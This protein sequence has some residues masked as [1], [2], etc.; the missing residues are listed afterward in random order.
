MRVGNA[1]TEKVARLDRYKDTAMLEG[2]QF[3]PYQLM[4]LLG[5]GGM[6][7]VYLAYDE[8]REREV[9][10]KVFVGHNA[11]Y[12]ERFR[13][14]AEAIDKLQ[15]PHILPAYDYDEQEPWRFLVLHYARGGTLRHRLAHGPLSLHE[16]GEM[17]TQI[18]DALQ[19]AH[20]QGVLHRDIKPS[21][22]LLDD[23]HY[24]Y[25]ADFGLAKIL[26]ATDNLTQTGA[27]MG[28]PE[29]MAPDLANGPAT[30]QTDIYALGV[31]LYQMLTGRVPFS[32]QNSVATYWMHLHEKPVAPS[33]IN[34]A[35]PP[36]IDRVVLRA[37]AK[38]PNRRYVSARDLVEAYYQALEYGTSLVVEEA[39][40]LVAEGVN[41]S[42][43]VVASGTSAYNP[44]YNGNI[45]EP[46]NVR[47]AY[48]SV[49]RGSSGGISGS[50]MRS[51]GRSS[52]HFYRVAYSFV[53][54]RRTRRK[55]KIARHRSQQH[56]TP[57]DTEALQP[58]ASSNEDEYR[59]RLPRRRKKMMTMP[60]MPSYMQRLSYNFARGRAQARKKNLPPLAETTGL[61]EIRHSQ[62]GFTIMAIIVG[63]LILCIVLLAFFYYISTTH[64][65]A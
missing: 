58:G 17:L 10:V 4:R 25:L 31:V 34:P 52:R 63:F 45:V 12:I 13:R 2:T 46:V 44:A 36:A 6:A 30:V 26:D 50:S 20:D 57:V 27:L 60:S 55:N 49:S 54:E 41:G 21:N 29:Y 65:L 9:A 59:Y 24:A 62:Y 19:F 16:T 1:T 8:L 3:G 61:E 56:L 48:D 38:N 42:T 47:N 51:R 22:I 14:E 53:Q 5:Q 39:E 23:D 43:Q 37:M 33:H 28:T 40:E 11:E 15:H 35:I 32:G 64:G 7:E 18:A